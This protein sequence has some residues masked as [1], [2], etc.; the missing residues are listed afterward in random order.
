MLCVLATACGEPVET[1]APVRLRASGSATMSSV[2]SELVTGFHERFPQISVEVSG[3]DTQ[4]GLQALQAGDTDL[5]LA[6]WLPGD[7]DPQWHSAPLARDGIAV[8]VHP[9]NPVRGLGLLQLQDLFSGRVDDWRSVGGLTT[10]DLVQP[11]TR[12]LG[13]GTRQAFESMVMVDQPMTPRTIVAPSSHAVLDYVAAHRQAIGYLSMS[14]LTPAVKVLQ[15]EG[16]MPSLASIADGTYALTRELWFVYGD[17]AS[18][19]LQAF[20]DFVRSPASQELIG[21]RFSAVR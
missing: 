13:S 7:P 5:A 20:L 3:L 6:S 9:D 14:E 19:A 1:P 8:V 18:Q 11:V 12:E 17:P 15:I 4:L 2:V 16:V 10:G 21:L